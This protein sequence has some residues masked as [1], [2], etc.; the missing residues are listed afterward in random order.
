MVFPVLNFRGGPN[1]F[2]EKRRNEGFP[3]GSIST[4]DQRSFAVS[5]LAD[6]TFNITNELHHVLILLYIG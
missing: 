4:G 6:G 1:V 3:Q 5:I 2:T